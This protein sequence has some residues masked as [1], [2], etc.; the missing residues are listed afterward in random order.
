[1]KSG[2]CKYGSENSWFNHGASVNS[3]KNEKLN[4]KEEVIE[5]IFEKMKKCTQ[6]IVKV[7]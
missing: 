2:T 1:V 5:K 3:Y 7:K 4:V 6:Q